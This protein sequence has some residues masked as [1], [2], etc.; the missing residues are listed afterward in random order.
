MPLQKNYLP[1]TLLIL[2]IILAEYLLLSGCAQI[3]SLGGGE[4]DTIP[5][6]IDT[7]LS[8]PNMQTR[9]TPKRIELHFDEFINLTDVFTQVVVSPPLQGMK[10][11]KPRYKMVLVEFD[12]AEPFRENATYTINFGTAIKDFTEGNVSPFRFVFSTGDYIDSLRIGGKVV[13]AYSKEPVPDVLVMLY[14]NLADSVVRTERPF[15]FART[16][17]QGLFQIENI[18]PDRFKVFALIDGNLNYLYDQDTERIGFLEEPVLLHDSLSVPDIRIRLFRETPPLR[19]VNRDVRNYGRMKLLFNRAPYDAAIRIEPESYVLAQETELDTI[20]IFYNFEEG[21]RM[22]VFVGEDTITLEGRNRAEF[23]SKGSLQL[24]KPF[25]ERQLLPV[26]PV[27]RGVRL[28]FNHPLAA[29]DSTRFLLKQ[30]TLEDMLQPRV[31][32]DSTHRRQMRLEFPF[33]EAVPYSLTI[34][35]DAVRDVFGFSNTDTLRTSLQLRSRKELANLILKVDQLDSSM[36]Y[37]LEL[38]QQKELVETM[39]VSGETEYSR[40]FASINPGEYQLRVT[41]DRNGNG[42]WDPGNY[43]EGQQPERITVLR[44]ET[45][46]ANW[47]LETTVSVTFDE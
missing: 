39:L 21:A 45:L 14:D 36:A 1:P 38:I 7:L 5:P 2:W 28:D 20:R 25:G 23:E 12:P 30:D 46:R 37:V 11:T 41:E 6:Q 47:D 29:L 32:L 33:E 43:D 9:F 40:T 27:D 15:Y 17:K 8:T 44:L 13:D 24:R 42:R 19:L 26:S 35:P 34:L 31:F 10:V 16:D 4:R 18:R 3:G 22:Q